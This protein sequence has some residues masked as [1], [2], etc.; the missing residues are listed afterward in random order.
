MGQAGAVAGARGSSGNGDKAPDPTCVYALAEGLRWSCIIAG[1]RPLALLPRWCLAAGAAPTPAKS[2][3]LPRPA[4]ETTECCLLVGALVGG[5]RV[6]LKPA[7]QTDC[8]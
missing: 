4:Q 3:I 5:R 1:G 2:H 7:E 6:A 8:D